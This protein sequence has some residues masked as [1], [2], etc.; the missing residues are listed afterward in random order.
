MLSSI[1]SGSILSHSKN[2]DG[3]KV[4][5]PVFDLSPI[6]AKIGKKEDLRIDDL[7][8]VLE[9]REKQSGEKFV[10]SIGYV[11]SKKVADKQK[12]NIKISIHRF[13]MR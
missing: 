6:Q 13:L 1:F 8:Q 5:T 11:R 3:F 9:N 4:K 7:Y 10:K 2:Y 12:K